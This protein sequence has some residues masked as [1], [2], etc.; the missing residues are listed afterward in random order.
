VNV[1]ERGRLLCYDTSVGD[2]EFGISA[3]T[4]RVESG[5]HFCPDR[6]ALRPRAE[7]FD[8]TGNVPAQNQWKLVVQPL[9]L[10]A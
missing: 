5:K 1:I 2:R 3:I 9:L 8:D 10:T 6:R 7:R 4:S